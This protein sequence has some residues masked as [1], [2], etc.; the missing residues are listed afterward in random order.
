MNG[1]TQK[2]KRKIEKNGKKYM[3]LRQI[4]FL[5]LKDMTVIFY[6]KEK[7]FITMTYI[8]GNSLLKKE[9]NL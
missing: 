4:I 9:W 8:N 3:H 5:E 6:K 2:L 7:I 1:M